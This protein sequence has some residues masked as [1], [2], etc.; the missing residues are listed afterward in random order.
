MLVR[1]DPYRHF[2]KPIDVAGVAV[3]SDL[4]LDSD[5]GEATLLFSKTGLDPRKRV[6]GPVLANEIDV[7]ALPGA[8]GEGGWRTSAGRSIP[9]PY[10]VAEEAFFPPKLAE[11]QLS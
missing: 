4:L 9:L 6:Y 2:L 7:E 11:I 3:A 1:E 10:V 5:A 8:I